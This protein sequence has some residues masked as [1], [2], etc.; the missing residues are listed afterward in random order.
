MKCPLSHRLSATAPLAPQSVIESCVKC[1]RDGVAAAEVNDVAVLQEA[2]VDLLVVDVGPVRRI[3]VDQQ[4][5][6][7]DRD[8]LGVQPGNLRIFQYDLTNRRFASD[9]DARS[10]ESEFLSGARS[11]KDG[12]LPEDAPV[13]T[14][15]APVGATTVSTVAAL[16][17]S[18]RV[19][20]ACANGTAASP[21]TTMPASAR[22][23]MTMA[24]IGCRRQ[25]GIIRDGAVGVVAEADQVG[26]LRE[27]H[28]TRCASS[29]S[30]SSHLPSRAAS[31]AAR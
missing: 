12:E 25:M 2:F 5:F 20:A 15:S 10:A 3:P 18:G 9:P 31:S 27:E 28:A 8:D 26:R 6:A 24:A 29:P 11:V 13:P 22:T 1:H 17:R 14:R 30:A 4:D 23:A 7:V 21:A 16:K 19:S